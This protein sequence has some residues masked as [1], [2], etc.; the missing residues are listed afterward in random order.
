MTMD[1]AHGLLRG[2]GLPA[3]WADQRQW[4]VLETALGDGRHFLALWAAWLQDPNRPALLHHVALTAQPPDAALLVEAIAREPSLAPLRPD[5]DTLREAWQGLLP[6]F[7]RLNFAGD[8]VQLTL[9]VAPNPH[10]GPRNDLRDQLRELAFE[11]DTVWF[12]HPTAET[13]AP[14]R[15]LTP[16]VAPVEPPGQEA[17][18][19]TGLIKALPSLCHRGTH[20]ATSPVTATVREALRAALR[21]CGFEPTPAA[22]ETEAVAGLQALFTPRWTPRKAANA[23]I[24]VKVP[25]HCFVIGGGLAGAATAFSLARRGWQVTVLDR[26]AEPAAG[27][28]GLPAGLVAPHVSADDRALSRLTRSGVRATLDRARALLRE[29]MDWQRS[30][31]LEHRVKDSRDLPPDWLDSESPGQAWSRPATPDQLA[32]AGLPTDR[33]AHWH[34]RAGWVRPAALVRAM[35]AQPG[36]TWHGGQAVARLERTATG[37]RALDAQGATLAQAELAV[38]AAGY[39]TRALLEDLG[40][41]TLPINALRGQIAWAPVPDGAAP[42]P[43]FPVNG[44]GSLISGLGLEGQPAWIF[45]S[46]FERGC[47][48]ALLRPE[49]T[50]ANF[51]K[52]ATLLPATA[53][54]LR[55]QFDAGQT[56]AWAAV[57]CTTPERVP[58]VGP[59]DPDALPGLWACTAMGA[60]GITLG[61]LCGELLAAQLHG[62]PLAVPVKQ[63]RALSPQRWPRV[64]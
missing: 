47:A 38:V 22:E 28:S 27:A 39:D 35:L 3:A 46:T 13:A 24:P 51:D 21:T 20:L 54:T 4:R 63:A 55:P 57:R 58:I 48:E 56:R 60:R 9:C 42:L 59:V 50:Q 10:A 49:D 23:I 1:S 53:E 37:W 8:R 40:A 41:P 43:P 7:H 2:T 14:D 33:P 5:A 61:V 15:G 34:A 36:I 45:G 30:G 17:A 31:V 12:N 29:G 11:A 64:A 32:Q 16:A 18:F 25:G 62:E 52:L 6:G 26:G 19:D 44:S